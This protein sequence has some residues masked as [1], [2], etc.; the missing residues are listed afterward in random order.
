MWTA[1]KLSNGQ[2][3]SGH[4][5]FG[6]FV[7]TKNGHHVVEHE[8]SWQGFKTQ[9]SRYVDDKLTVVVLANLAEAKPKIFADH[10]AEMY[11]SGKIKA[12]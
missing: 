3:N 5:G 10:V 12:P 8:G 6:W 7:E 9:I 1:A 2:E 11:L 4:Y